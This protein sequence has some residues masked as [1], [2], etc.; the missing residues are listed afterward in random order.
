MHDNLHVA[1]SPQHHR[2]DQVL[3]WVEYAACTGSTQK[4]C[5]ISADVPTSVVL[6]VIL[7]SQAEP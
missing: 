1:L 4:E 6:F 3:P 5:F 7:R 2:A